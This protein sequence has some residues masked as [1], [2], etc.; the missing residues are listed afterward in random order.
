M[1]SCLVKACLCT[2]KAPPTSTTETRHPMPIGGVRVAPT[3]GFP[4]AC[5][6]TTG[7]TQAVSSSLKQSQAVLH[8]QHTHIGTEFLSGQ[9]SHVASHTFGKFCQKFTARPVNGVLNDVVAVLVLHQGQPTPYH[10]VKQRFLG[11]AWSSLDIEKRIRKYRSKNVSSD[12]GMRVGRCGSATQ[13]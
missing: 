10:F 2:S 3:T 8:N 1:S 5:F 7:S 11:F 13:K 6:G 9:R 4:I 12:R